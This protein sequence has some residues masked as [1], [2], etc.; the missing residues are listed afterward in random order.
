MIGLKALLLQLAALVLTSVLSVIVQKFLGYLIPPSVFLSLH[1]S[2]ALSFS[3]L[4]RFDWWWSLIQVL[5]PLLL[6]LAA[7]HPLPSQWYL[8]AF[9]IF[10]LLYWSTFRTQVPYYPSKKSLLMPIQALLPAVQ[11]SRFV[12]LG[13]GMGGLLMQLAKLNPEGQFIGVEIAPLPW[14]ISRLRAFLSSSK[15]KFVLGNYNRQDLQQFDV[16]FCYL[17]P[18]AMPSIWE[19]AR[20]EMKPGALLLSYEFIIPEKPHDFCVKIEE[21]APYLF[22]WRI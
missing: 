20:A 12:D 15:V 5:F 21:D 19:K 17:S 10:A 4:F 9:L 3:M 7:L 8:F 14:L 2:V 6:V 11:G 13:S 18:A 1:V 22:G 16:V